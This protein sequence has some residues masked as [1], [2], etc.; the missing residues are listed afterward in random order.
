MKGEE[1]LERFEID[2]FKKDDGTCPVV[3]FLDSL[4]VKMQAKV[5]R[6]IE[7]LEKNGYEL[8]EPY[9]KLLEDGIFE[10]RI[11]QG[12][13]ITRVLYFFFVNRK[14]ILTNGFVKKTLKMPKNE[15]ALARKYRNVY[16]EKEGDFKWV[17]LEN[18]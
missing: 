9:S 8:R 1:I 2:F 17:I 4:D 13:N 12:S 5:L 10:L 7:L 16:M 6:T 15:I 14:I 3:D 11:K 18:I